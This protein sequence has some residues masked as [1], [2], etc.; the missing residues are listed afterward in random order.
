MEILGFLS[1]CGNL[2][3]PNKYNAN[4][5]ATMIQ[6][7]MKSSLF[8]KNVLETRSALDKNFKAKASS[9]KPKTTFTVFIHPPDFGRLCNAC[10]NKAKSPKTIA[11]ARPNPAN[12]NVNNIGTLV[13]PVTALPS[14]LPKIGPVQE[15]ETITNVNAMKKI[16]ISPPAS[17]ALED[18]LAIELGKVIS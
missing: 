15:K 12:A 18:L 9:T 4:P 14:K 17:S 5:N 6:I 11:H 8:K 16:P 13:E 10:G 1:S 3:N 7:A 2:I